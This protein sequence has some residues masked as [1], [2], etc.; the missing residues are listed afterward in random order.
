MVLAMSTLAAGGAVGHQG[1]EV[2]TT[3]DP[4]R[5]LDL[6]A[7]AGGISQG[8]HQAS[9]RY[10]VVRAVE[11]DGAAAATHAVNF[12]DVV[13]AGPIQSWLAEESVPSVDV[14]VGGP[15]CQG[16]S[17]LGKQ[18][19]EDVRNVLWREY[20]ETVRRAGPSYFVLENVPAFRRSAQFELF[21]A[22]M[23][24]GGPLEDYTFDVHLLNAADYGAAQLRKRVVVI[25]RHR[26]LPS[27][28]APATT[29]IGRH[30]TLR[31]V[32]AGVPAHLE[33]DAIDLPARSAVGG[34]GTMPGPF[35]SFELHVTRHYTD[36]SR[37][38]FS[39]IPAGGNRTDIPRELLSPCWQRHTT[40]SLDV[41]GRLRWDS[42]SVTVRTE[43]FKPEKGRYLHPEEHRAITHYEAALIQGFP[44]DFQWYGHKNAIARQIGNAVPVPLARAIGHHL[45]VA[46]DAHRGTPT[47][48]SA[49]PAEDRVVLPHRGGQL[50]GVGG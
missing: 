6:F 46:I 1:E 4:I 13:F 5:V 39:H 11:M 31:Q 10:E 8:M 43:F 2:G 19:A 24:P 41:M 34:A 45:A 40:G 3:G 23:E 37:Q 22:A 42:P 32:L 16:F 27:P 26:D 18:D 28:G 17:T 35:R 33:E 50:V 21:A 36:L 20:V 47:T 29:H 48:I 7:G 49:T 30:R 44:D 12:G 38:R 25:G 9:A 15:P 14:V